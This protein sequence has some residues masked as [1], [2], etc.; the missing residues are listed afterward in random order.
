MKFYEKA[1][2]TLKFNTL[3]IPIKGKEWKK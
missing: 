1:L 2:K 3:L